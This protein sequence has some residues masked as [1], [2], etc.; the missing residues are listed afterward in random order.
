MICVDASVAAKWIFPEEYSAESLALVRDAA[1]RGERLIAPQLLPIEVNNIV[2]RRMRGD[3]L[4]LTQAR[5]LLA[6]FLAVP[7]TLTPTTPGDRKRLHDHALTLADRFELP[8]VYDAYYLAV[9]NLR[10]CPLWT[11]DRQLLRAVR[12]GGP[13]VRWIADYPGQ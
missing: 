6:A 12:P 8:A 1:R 11:D 4:T 2:R 3:G 5:E 10:Q 7:V 13:N 9:A